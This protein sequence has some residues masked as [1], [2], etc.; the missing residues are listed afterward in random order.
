MVVVDTGNPTLEGNV[1]TTHDEKHRPLSPTS[2]I[3][4]QKFEGHKG[5]GYLM[6]RSRC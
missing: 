2:E 4:R 3:Y 6:R 1:A 5:T